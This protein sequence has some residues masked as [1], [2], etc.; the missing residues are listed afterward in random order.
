MGCVT[1]RDFC[2]YDTKNG[3]TYTGNI[4]N[5][6]TNPIEENNL[7]TTINFFDSMPGKTTK[8]SISSQ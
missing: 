2:E 8:M 1:R 3:T 4:K 6:K 7:S 5:N